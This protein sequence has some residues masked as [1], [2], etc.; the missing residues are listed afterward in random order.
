MKLSDDNK[1]TLF[2][3]LLFVALYVFFL[4]PILVKL[5]I[6]KGRGEREADNEIENP[7]SPWGTK[8]WH[9]YLAPKNLIGANVIKGRK[10]VTAEQEKRLNKAAE[11]CY[12]SMGTISD[13]EGLFFSGLALC[14][15]KAEVSL[16]SDIFTI[17]Y[18]MNIL[19]WIKDG[20]GVLPENGLSSEELNQALNYV[21]NLP[22]A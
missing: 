18:K 19:Q 15:T 9:D 17:R 13:N 11:M 3:V 4:H 6:A 10:V 20:Q 8:F 16:M 7:N 2:K 1:Q 12:D 21:K 14:K 22:T 5:G